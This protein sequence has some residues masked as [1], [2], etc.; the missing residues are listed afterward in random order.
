MNTNYKENESFMLILAPGKEGMVLETAGVT[1]DSELFL[2]LYFCTPP[3]SRKN[4]LIVIQT[5]FMEDLSAVLVFASSQEEN[6]ILQSL[7]SC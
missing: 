7:Y 2:F 1:G 6:V 4:E 3:V 5:I